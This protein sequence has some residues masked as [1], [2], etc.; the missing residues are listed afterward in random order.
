MPLAHDWFPG[1]IPANVE[2][3]ADAY[4]DSSYSFAAFSS[5]RTPGLV[6]GTASGVYNRSTI[7]T[8]PA[9]RVDIGSFTVLNASVIAC[10][11]RVV[12]GSHCLLS[13]GVVV[14]DS[15]LPQGDSLE[16][17]RAAMRSVA[18]DPLRRVPSIAAPRPVTIEDNVWIGFDSV[19]MPGVRLGRGCIVG[20]KCV[21]EQDVPAYTVV[22]GNPARVVRTLD[23]DD[24][25]EARAR[26]LA[27]CVRPR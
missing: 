6:L 11:E 7:A 1:A 8:G 26:A 18:S 5:T 27:E 17:R 9:G 10:M 16:A 3:G 22:V 13:W 23:A 12:I 20:A 15:W 14:T 21:V 4:L 19:I 2:I 25:S 24:T